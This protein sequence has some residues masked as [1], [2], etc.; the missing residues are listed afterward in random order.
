[1]AAK[2]TTADEQA[3][4]LAIAFHY[5]YERLAPSFGYETR[6]ETRSFDP[7]S[8]NGRLMV[9]TCRELLATNLLPE[10]HTPNMAYQFG[11]RVARC[12]ESLDANLLPQAQLIVGSRSIPLNVIGVVTDPESL[13]NTVQA[14]ILEAP[15]GSLVNIF[16][17]LDA[18]DDTVHGYREDQP[19]PIGWHDI[20]GAFS[21]DNLP[22]LSSRRTS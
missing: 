6:E 7:E 15:P 8:K 14:T 18:A 20:D 12:R 3:L 2:T 1:M 22:N 9:A 11:Q 10:R 4:E 17:R 16:S 13:D 19:A 5:I 21:G